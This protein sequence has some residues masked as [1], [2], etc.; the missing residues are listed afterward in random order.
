M[1]GPQK[2]ER[3]SDSS[4]LP[5]VSPVSDALPYARPTAEIRLIDNEKA[6]RQAAKL[7]AKEKEIGFD[8]ET[9]YFDEHSRGKLALVQI[10]LPKQNVTLLVD[11][12]VSSDDATRTVVHRDLSALKAVL[13][14]PK[15]RKIA[16]SSGFDKKVM[17]QVGIEI[18]EIF[19]TQKLLKQVHPEL[20]RTGLK[21]A[22]RY[23]LGLDVEKEQQ[24]SPWQ[25]RPLDSDQFRYAALDPEI[26]YKLY[27]ELDKTAQRAKYIAKLDIKKSMQTLDTKLRAIDDYIDREVPELRVLEAMKS[28]LSAALADRHPGGTAPYQGPDGA[29]FPGSPQGNISIEKLTAALDRMA[30]APDLRAE[31]DRA[32]EEAG[33]K[34]PSKKK[35]YETII[36]RGH[37][38]LGFDSKKA[39][40]TYL[41]TFMSRGEKGDA[42]LEPAYA[43]KNAELPAIDLSRD[44]ESLMEELSKIS[45]QILTIFK[46]HSDE[47]VVLRYETKALSA[48]IM[49]DLLESLPDGYTSEYGTVRIKDRQPAL[50]ME[51]VKA[52]LPKRLAPAL[53]AKDAAALIESTYEVSLNKTVLGK[54]LVDEK[55]AS[56]GFIDDD[57]RGALWQEVVIPNGKYSATKVYPNI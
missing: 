7:I 23:V 8:T 25:K 47:L 16:H 24:T 38:A 14:D 28:A 32:I 22:C 44:D 20:P 29:I 49:D 10:Y 15:R 53:E 45:K 11:P 9:A 40:D 2:E 46:A 36:A 56:L 27:S 17:E 3:K 42:A 1:M 12:I 26:A 37:E 54:L 51:R 34:Q 19:D 43:L 6:L 52:E 33:R 13:E 48:H 39:V 21:P 4:G 57:R 31:L 30:I 55:Y 35:L 18:D 5:P 41:G 50:D